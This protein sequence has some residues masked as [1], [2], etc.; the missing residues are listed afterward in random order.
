MKRTALATL[1]IVVGLLVAVAGIIP[2]SRRVIVTE[3]K[4]MQVTEYREE[5]RTKEEIYYE[6][7]VI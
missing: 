1:I 3:E 7:T 5:N 6:E 4:I 2:L